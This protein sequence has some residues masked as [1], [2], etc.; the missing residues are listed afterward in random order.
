MMSNPVQSKK[1]EQMD[2]KK[3]FG[4]AFLGLVVMGVLGMTVWVVKAYRSPLGPALQVPTP[5]AIPVNNQVASP[6]A[7]A[8]VPIT[9]QTDVCG[10]TGVWNVLVLGSDA[11]DLR[12]EKG[13]DLTRMV[14]VDFP[15][16]K[17]TMFAF[18]R[19]LWVDTAG[20]GLTN[21]RIDT[22]QL[23]RVFYEARRRSTSMDVKTA[24]IDGTNVTAR[25]L[26]QNFLVSSDHYLT[27]DLAQIPAMVDAI[28]GVPINIPARTTDPWIGMVIPAGQQTLN[29]AQ[30]IAYARAIP[31]SDFARIQRN[32][33]LLDALQSK[34]LDPAVWG[35][36]PQ[37][38]TQFNEVIA[39]D[40]SPEQINHLA[41]LLQ[42]VPKEAILQDSV[43]QE[44]TSPGPQTGSLLW[45]KTSV[46]NRLKELGLIP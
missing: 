16:R 39:T 20:L 35:R 46:L 29:G 7:P 37:L 25:M 12:G 41:C 19:D 6:T 44:W 28:G 27:V 31:D 11:L 26:A 13:A 5:T 2:T 33:L 9:G 45:D 21:P 17:V 42:E 18:S 1:E 3:I 10:E 4:L 8:I 38:Y 15:N 32:N 30:F 40:L 24:M 34:L 43:R 36:I 23:G 22:T 14:R